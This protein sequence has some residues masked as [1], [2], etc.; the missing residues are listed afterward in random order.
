MV[1]GS[2]RGWERTSVKHPRRSGVS[3]YRCV[4]IETQTPSL[5]IYSSL[6]V[7]SNGIGPPIRFFLSWGIPLRA[8]TQTTSSRRVVESSSRPRSHPGWLSLFTDS[9]SKMTTRTYMF[10]DSRH[11]AVGNARARIPG[12]RRIRWNSFPPSMA[13]SLAPSATQ[14]AR[15]RSRISS[16]FEIDGAGREGTARQPSSTPL[17][18]ARK[19]GRPALAD[20]PPRAVTMRRDRWK[21][22]L[23]VVCRRRVACRGP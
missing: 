22:A 23:C 11:G 13:P 7:P 16:A 3:T 6:Y 2:E 12:L 15:E 5:C 8:T 1:R 10:I 14:N 19:V 9:T 20:C 17:G 18:N 21:R 4:P